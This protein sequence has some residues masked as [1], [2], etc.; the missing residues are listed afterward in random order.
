MYLINHKRD[1]MTMMM[2][3]KGRNETWATDNMKLIHTIRSIG[4]ALCHLFAYHSTNISYST[5]NQ[6]TVSSDFSC[7]IKNANAIGIET[8]QTL[9]GRATAQNY[10]DNKGISEV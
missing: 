1:P 10:I 2:M 4:F 6:W 7:L 5:Q 3:M 8:Q 9:F